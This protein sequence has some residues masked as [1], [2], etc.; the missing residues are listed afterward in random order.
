MMKVSLNGGELKK[1]V[2]RVLATR[3]PLQAFLKD[4]TWVEDAR[5]YVERQGKEVK[6]L[7]SADVTKV[8]AFLEKEK[9]ELV[10]FQKQIPGEVKKLRKFVTSQKKELEKLLSRV[11]KTGAGNGGTKK[12]SATR[13]AKKTKT[14]ATV[15]TVASAQ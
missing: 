12:A 7:L 13:T 9:K 5:K 4:R 10:K 2:D 15:E 6:K 14:V 1:V 8:K 11:R 3:A